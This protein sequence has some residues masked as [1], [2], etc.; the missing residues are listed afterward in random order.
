MVALRHQNHL[1]GRA[2]FPTS[3]PDVPNYQESHSETH[4]VTISHRVFFDNQIMRR[5]G[6]TKIHPEPRQHLHDTM[7]VI[8]VEEVIIY[9][10]IFFLLVLFSVYFIRCIRT[11]LDPYNTVARAAW[12]ETLNTRESKIFS[13][14]YRSQTVA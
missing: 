6:T 7:G 4:N 2:G 14:F 13:S 5:M 1:I 12:L 9:V 3:S 11:T 8:N 10:L